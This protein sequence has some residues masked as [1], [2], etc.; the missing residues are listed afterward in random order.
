MPPSAGRPDSCRI[1]E[2]VR[3]AL[4]RSSEPLPV[5]ET[6]RVRAAILFVDVCES[7][8]LFERLGE[9]AGRKH[10]RKA[11]DVAKS[12]IESREGRV[13]RVV[14]DAIL[15]VF[16][17][18]ASLVVAASS[19]QVALEGA[20][21]GA[22]ARDRV[23][24]HC[25]GHFGTVVIDASG[26]VFGEVANVA[27]RVQDLAG[28]DQIYV[29]AALVESLPEGHRAATR[30][31]GS[32]HV[33]GKRGEVDVYEVIWRMAGTTELSDQ[34]PRAEEVDLE[35]GYGDTRLTLQANG[36]PIKIGRWPGNDLL[37]NDRS[38]S[39]VHAEV[40]CRRGEWF[41][42]DRSTNGTFVRPGR[43]RAHFLHRDE[44]VLEGQGEFVLGRADGP[45][46]TYRLAPRAPG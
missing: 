25:G 12:A 34:R 6:N 20:G 13:V 19:V 36:S 38:V 10:V 39:R 15:S 31:I 41:L 40:S 21:G 23:K 43:R 45:P 26:E 33:R 46:I 37:V 8:A 22:H 7:T 3:R 42:K 44:R 2:M 24:V 18:A 14:G 28:P 4:R 11:L 32:F 35:L 16:A 1:G 17:D 27:S 5:G 29:T 30:R 9:M